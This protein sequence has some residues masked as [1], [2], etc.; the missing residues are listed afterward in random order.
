MVLVLL[1]L[2]SSPWTNLRFSDG[3]PTLLCDLIRNV[4]KDA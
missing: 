2:R 3:L 4:P 1:D